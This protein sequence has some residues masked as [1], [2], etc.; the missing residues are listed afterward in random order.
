MSLPTSLVAYCYFFTVSRDV[1]RPIMRLQG[2]DGLARWYRAMEF[3]LAGSLLQRARMHYLEG[4]PQPRQILL[5]GEG[6]G[7]L[8]EALLWRFPT[9]QC[10]VVDASQKMIQVAQQ[11]LKRRGIS[12][13]GITWLNQDVHEV[14]LAAHTYDLV[15]TPFFLD[16]FTETELQ[17]L[18]PRIAASMRP[19]G[20]WWVTDFQI[21]EEG[22]WSRWRAQGIHRLMYAFFGA[23][24]GL[25]ATRWVNPDPMLHE[26]GM[27]CLSRSTFQAG[28]IRSDCWG[29]PRPSGHQAFSESNRSF[30]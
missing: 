2:F 14:R 9:V 10:T 18:L 15:T 17:R 25:S 27:Q 24:T 22:A 12:C 21:P 29:W 16:C 19:E 7:R 1:I 6:P 11:R 20:H 26:L 13:D 30:K 8:L 5:L 3:L 28:L 4:I 23:V